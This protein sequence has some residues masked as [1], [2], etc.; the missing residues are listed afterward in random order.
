M[1]QV[2]EVKTLKQKKEFLSFPSRLYRNN[3]YYVPPMYGDELA[4]M[5]EKKNPAFSYAD[6]KYFLALREGETVGRIGAIFSRRSNEKWGKTRMRFTSVDFIDDY[7]VSAALFDAVERYAR[8]MD[9]AEVHGPLGFTDLDREG[10]LVEGFEEKSLFFTYYNAPYYKEHLSHL[11][12]EKDVDWVELQIFWPEEERAYSV[13]SRLAERAKKKHN[14]RVVNIKRRSQF[15][16]YI[17][18]AFALTNTAYAPLYGTVEL[19]EAQIKRY[20][21]KFVPLVDPDFACLVVNEKDELVAFGATAPSLSAAF[22]KNDGKLFPFG[23]IPVLRALKKNDCIDFLLVAV[24]PDLQG[25]GVNAIV[26]DSIMQG[27]RRRGIRYGETG[28]QLEENA[29]VLEQWKMFPSRQ[30]RRR[31]CFRKSLVEQTHAAETA[32]E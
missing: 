25:A 10:M 32:E 1:V 11:G 18:A 12:Y 17:R 3:P 30:H 28:P 7:E 13:L 15:K 29:K 2:V 22:R 6:A 16:P 8:E 31:R 14:L 4:D 5:N 26:I 21:D 9:C 27:C 20:A 23:F 24:H 19:D